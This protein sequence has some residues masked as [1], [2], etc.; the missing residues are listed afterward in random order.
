MQART[1]S[2]F[3]LILLWV[4]ILLAL[5]VLAARLFALTPMAHDLVESR[6]EALEVSGQTVEIEGLSGDLLGTIRVNA[7]TVSDR[8]GTWLAASDL[9]ARYSPLDLLRGTLD[10]GHLRAGA[11][12][13]ARRPELA[14]S[15]TNGNSSSGGFLDRYQIR[16]L[17]VSRLAF[18]DGVAGPRQAYAINGAADIGSA[19]GQARLSLMPEDAGGDRAEIDLE[20]SPDVPFTGRADMTGQPG[21]LIAGLLGA[22]EGEGVSA[23]L[24]AQDAANGWHMRGQAEVGD[25]PLIRLEARQTGE[26][27]ILDARLDFAPLQRLAG[28][29]E[30]LGGPADIS[31]DAAFGSDAP[32][33]FMLTAPNARLEATGTLQRGRDRLALTGLGARL[34]TSSAALLTGLEDLSFETITLAGDLARDNGQIRFNGETRITAPAY[35]ERRAETLRADGLAVWTGE[36]I[37][38]DLDLVA[39][40]LSGFG[41][42]LQ[43]YLSSRVTGAADLRAALS[44]LFI[45]A[46][47]I[48]LTSDVAQLTASGT[49]D[50]AGE[51]DMD[52]EL[53]LADA[54]GPVT[55]LR[56]DAS[57]TGRVDGRLSANVQASGR[58]DPQA[59]DLAALIGEEAQ[60]TAR[61][62]RTESGLIDISAARLTSRELVATFSGTAS[63]DALDLSYTM[64]REPLHHSGVSLTEARLDGTVTGTLETPRLTARL[65]TDQLETAGET[66]TALDFSAEFLLAEPMEI[67]A[68]GT[69]RY[70]GEPARIDLAG[71]YGNNA[72]QLTRF[73]LDAAGLNA[74]AE[75]QGSDFTLDASS[76]TATITGNPAGLGTLN[77]DIAL[78]EGDLNA[79]ARLS[80]LQAGP[81]QSGEFALS[82]TGNWPRYEARALLTGQS[83]IAGLVQNL[84]ARQ[85]LALNL[86]EKS[87]ETTLDA[88]L[89]DAQ[90]TTNGPVRIAFSDGLSAEGALTGLGGAMDFSLQQAET[91]AEAE[92]DLRG[93]ELS[94]IGPL[95]ARPFLRGTLSGTARYSASDTDTTGTARFTLAGLARGAPD[96]PQADLDLTASL[97]GARL[98]TT[99]AARQTGGGLDLDIALALPVETPPASF[100]LALRDRAPAELTVSGGGE[101][102]PLWALIAPAN[103]RFEGDLRAD[104]SAEA[105]LAELRP[106][107]TL[108]LQDALI[109]DG[110]TGLFLR[111]IHGSARLEPDRITVERL[112][113]DG[114]QGGTLTGSGAYGFDGDGSVSL[115]LAALNAFNREDITATISGTLSVARGAD[116]TEVEGDLDIE[117]AEI[118][119]NQLPGGGYTTLDVSFGNAADEDE[120]PS[121]PS[122]RDRV[123]LNVSLEADNQIYV[124]G[125]AIETEWRADVDI[126]GTASEPLLNGT[127]NL[128][129]G[130]ASLLS[131]SFRLREGVIRFTGPIEDTEIDIRA[132]RESDDVTVTIALV[133]SPTD[134]DLELSSEPALPEDEILSRVLFGRSPSQ[135]SA[136]QAAQLAGA[137]A[138]LAGG[139]GGLN[140]LGSLQDAA[141]L[142][143]LDLGFGEDGSAVIG[144]GKYLADDV[145]LTVETGL[146]GVPGVSV[147]WTPLDNVEVDATLNSETGQRIAIQWKHDFDRLPFEEGE[148]EGAPRGEGD[149][150]PRPTPSSE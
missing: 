116:G 35:Q 54:P 88:R 97:H 38:T 11:I 142:D 44:P 138:S 40:D 14:E 93:I 23:Q 148:E 124:T 55:T 115:D 29:S 107:G 16:E 95:F 77:A 96:A 74:S 49:F 3:R 103:I 53:R 59:G 33:R 140:L 57:A 110:L 65:L 56:L 118:D 8:G 82:I 109:E 121:E 137:A 6:L 5:L 39:I 134:P 61:L 72:W 92:L 37:E 114:S 106:T 83:E 13:I 24:L 60:L 9:S 120:P 31:L 47:R 147:E 144:A 86:E 131:R 75:G 21:G 94:A 108:T 149:G 136:F 105:P 10:L 26:R 30:R 22:P 45:T 122:P 90:L 78:R 51:I 133:G 62:T 112:T 98:E 91:H 15:D 7:L 2:L 85:R 102:A 69:A 141:D 68:G 126:T 113:A 127:A 41:D 139:G 125:P 36:A 66:L 64:Q 70:R 143:S 27:V 48:T 43:P 132:R 18:A 52:A 34:E 67:E 1:R 89:G 80:G 130:E 63:P 20:W 101:I 99:I 123:S 129:R 145:Y 71:T 50:K 87:G 146:S 32:A 81:L 111:N 58:L 79:D 17:T 42:T 100:A 73:D 84:T 25:A 4:P 150:Q 119:L 104:L 12:E 128:V 28:L 19:S 135:I 76:L 117:R 46:D